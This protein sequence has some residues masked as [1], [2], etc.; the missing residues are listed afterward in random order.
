M[1]ELVLVACAY[2][3]YTTMRLVVEGSRTAATANALRVLRFE[4]AVGFDFERN[5][6]GWALARP[7]AESFWNFVYTWVYWPAVAIA[8][9]L[10]WYIDRIGYFVLRNTLMTSAAVG[11]VI[12]GLFPVSPPRF[13]DGYVDT[14]TVS[15]DR[16]I[17]ERGPLVNEY[18]AVPSFHV[19]WPAVAGLIVAL[20]SARLVVRVAAMAPALL[21]APAVVFTGNHFVFDVLVG[22]AVALASLAVAERIS[23]RHVTVG[24]T[25]E[26]SRPTGELASTS[27][28]T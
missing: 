2:V 18:A 11:L 19:A 4:R 9:V 12:F 5:A 27:N 26:S 14:L 10:L 6:Q 22:L 7:T 24:E 3:V 20:S 21:L 1:A 16:V 23:T 8:L 25:D 13:L 28:R 17:S 15:G